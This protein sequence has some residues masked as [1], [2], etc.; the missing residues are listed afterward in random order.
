MEAAEL[1]MNAGYRGDG[2]GLGGL[3]PGV[4]AAHPRKRNDS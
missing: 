4:Q 3:E 2:E 1:A